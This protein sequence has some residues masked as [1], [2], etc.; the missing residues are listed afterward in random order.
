VWHRE[1]HVG[2]AARG[3]QVHAVGIDENGLRL[4]KELGA[5]QVMR[6]DEAAEDHCTVSVEA[7]GAPAAIT[8]AARSITAGGRVAL[9][10]IAHHSVNDFP[11]AELTIK[12][13]N[14]QA[15]L[16]GID[17]WDQLINI[18]ASG[19]LRLEPLLERVVPFT[20]AEAAFR[21]QARRN[22]AKPKLLLGFAQD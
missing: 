5:D 14:I 18:A 15:V 8:Q 6:P 1:A 22:T 10:G 17:Y 19:A 11:A 20:D 4:A 13:A 7:S 3:A 9:I 12:D 2:S 21:L 16:S